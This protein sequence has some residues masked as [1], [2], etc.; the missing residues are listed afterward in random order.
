MR[1]ALPSS[2]A[3]TTVDPV[4]VVRFCTRTMP[5]YMVPRFLSL[6][7]ALPYTCTGR[8]EKYQLR[9]HARNHRVELWDRKRLV[10]LQRLRN[11]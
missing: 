5:H 4:E 8:V 1:S 2:R 10:E 3:G 6:I 9:D 7:E 11:N